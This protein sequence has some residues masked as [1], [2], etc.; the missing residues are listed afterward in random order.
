ML[1]K[2][3]SLELAQHVYTK[4]KPLTTSPKADGINNVLDMFFNTLDT[5]TNYMN[6]DIF[7]WLLTL[8]DA[9]SNL[10]EAMFNAVTNGRRDLVDALVEVN[11]NVDIVN[12]QY[13]GYH[14]LFTA[15][16][17]ND[18]GIIDLVYNA[19]TPKIDLNQRDNH[20]A[21]HA[22]RSLTKTG[23]EWL[24]D[25]HNN[26]NNGNHIDFDFIDNE[27]IHFYTTSQL[28]TLM[29]SSLHYNNHALFNISIP[30]IHMAIARLHNN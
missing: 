29:C 14:L 27:G 22:L 17:Q 18:R 28:I 20:G 26:N 9:T 7:K 4:Y 11:A 13:S 2:G 16:N 5:Y 24:L 25:Q 1:S 21:V 10:N 8:P 3:Q 6:V 19:T 30:Q 23:L 12:Y 15:L